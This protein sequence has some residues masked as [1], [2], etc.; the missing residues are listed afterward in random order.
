MQR[1]VI[2]SGYEGREAIAIFEHCARTN[3]KHRFCQYARDVQWNET[4]IGSVDWIQEI[5]GIIKPD[6]FPEWLRHLVKR[7]WW[8]L[9]EP[10]NEGES[11]PDF[12]HIK[13]LDRYKRFDGCN[14]LQATIN[15][16]KLPFLCQENVTFHNE[17]RIY[18]SNGVILDICWYKGKDQHKKKP[19][20]RI[21]HGTDESHYKIWGEPPNTYSDYI[22]FKVPIKFCGTIDIGETD[23][24][25]QL[26]E[27]HH[28]FAIGWYGN[29]SSDYAEFCA[30]GWEYMRN[31]P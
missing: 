18:V 9:E 20:S 2:Q 28:P 25:I 6:Y 30:K 8:L 26:V 14:I 10:L 12:C 16:H 15:G 31:L 3:D 27:C 22:I 13:P 7:K 4:P 19:I 5:T 29:K 21:H 11:L 17:W 24:G 1:F 23:Q